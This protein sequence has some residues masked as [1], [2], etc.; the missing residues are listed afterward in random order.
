MVSSSHPLI[1]LHNNI[2]TSTINI[3]Q[4]SDLVNTTYQCSLHYGMAGPILDIKTEIAVTPAPSPA[5]SGG[6]YY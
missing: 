2:S 6:Y 4:S 5:A 1:I 3:T